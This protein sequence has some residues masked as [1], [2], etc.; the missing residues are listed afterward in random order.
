MTTPQLLEL[1]DQTIS[2]YESA[3]L[4]PARSRMDESDCPTHDLV[5]CSLSQTR[6]TKRSSGARAEMTRTHRDQLAP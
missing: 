3:T 6:K 1:I 5:N 2:E 4:M